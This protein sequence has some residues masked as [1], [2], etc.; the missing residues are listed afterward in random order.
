LNLFISLVEEAYVVVEI[1]NKKSWIYK[2]IKIEPQLVN[3]KLHSKKSLLHTKDYFKNLQKGLVKKKS[4]SFKS[5]QLF[6]KKD[7]L[8]DD[9][10]L[11]PKKSI[12]SFTHLR[13]DESLGVD[14]TIIDRNT[15]I[16]TNRRYLQIWKKVN[17]DL[18]RYMKVLLILKDSAIK[19]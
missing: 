1:K 17:A 3:L 4:Q 16:D 8:T 11:K 2:Y 12:K 19:R 18:H 15:I 7:S 6:V 10:K 13:Q 14:N 9:L 5:H